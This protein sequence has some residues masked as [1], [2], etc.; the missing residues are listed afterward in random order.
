MEENRPAGVLSNDLGESRA[1][2]LFAD[3]MEGNIPA[4]AP[5]TDLEERIASIAPDD[6]EDNE[7][8]QEPA[9]PAVNMG[10]VWERIGSRRSGASRFFDR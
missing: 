8:T 3:H 1:S 4:N 7:P 2:H 6:G 9:S 10:D 5:A